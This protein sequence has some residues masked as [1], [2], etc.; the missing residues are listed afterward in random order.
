MLR[1]HAAG[2]G[3][4]FP[5]GGKGEGEKKII[6]SCTPPLVPSR[7]SSFDFF[8]WSQGPWT[9]SLGPTHARAAATQLFRAENRIRA[10]SCLLSLTKRVARGRKRQ[11]ALLA[12]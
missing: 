2:N 7:T 9:G 8:F 5:C 10:L 12:T 4:I 11:R 6:L 1:D 3:N